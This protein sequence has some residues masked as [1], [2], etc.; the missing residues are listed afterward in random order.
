MAI[1][2]EIKIEEFQAQDC[3]ASNVNFVVD[4]L[5]IG[6]NGPPKYKHINIEGYLGK[7]QGEPPN[8]DLTKLS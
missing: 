4:M 2:C 8:F 5:K 1:S 7:L 3:F 6:F